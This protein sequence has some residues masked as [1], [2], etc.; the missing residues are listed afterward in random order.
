MSAQKDTS[1]R[2][3]H[4]SGAFTLI[5]LL[6]VIAIIAILAAM[7][8]PALANAK[9]KAKRASCLSNMRQWGLAVQMYAGDNRDGIPQDGYSDSPSATYPGSGQ[10]GTPDD[11]RAW[12]NN[13]PPYVAEKPL[14][15]FFHDTT[16]TDNTVKMPF[17][18]NGRGKIYQCP[19]ATMTQAEATSVVSGGGAD[20]YFSY[21]MNIDLK[22]MADTTVPNGPEQMPKITALHRPTDTV[23]M[24]DLVFSPSTEIVNSSPQFNSVNPAGRWRSFCGRHT[25]GG[26]INFFDGHAFYYKT[27][28]V[29]A[30]G[31][32]TGTAVELPGSP[33][34]WNPRFRDLKP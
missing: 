29:Q 21:G 2:G 34:I 31:T 8:L 18:G 11:P 16:V 6:V 19:S 30:G 9:E 25:K 33:L 17:P 3:R 14:T 28:V 22:R 1:Y 26:L 12:F 24:L 32:M 5:E 4:S 20:G 15:E 13:L 10:N 7:L 27:D 23:F